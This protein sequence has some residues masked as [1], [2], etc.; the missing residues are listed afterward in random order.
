MEVR[1]RE[2]E[3]GKR[4]GGKKEGQENINNR[5]ART[6][7]GRR[8][9]DVHIWVPTGRTQLKTEPELLLKLNLSYV[10]GFTYQ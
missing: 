4:K 8:R 3:K 1:G 10:P 7:Y 2:D 6:R 9:R 5:K